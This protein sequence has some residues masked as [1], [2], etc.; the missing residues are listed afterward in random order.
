MHWDLPEKEKDRERGEK[1]VAVG[2]GDSRR[3][4]GWGSVVEKRALFLAEGVEG[5]NLGK[6]S[7][8][9]RRK[10]AEET[11]RKVRGKKV[12]L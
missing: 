7:L 5:R 3:F 10:E 8:G 2:K 11:T 6:G 9:K 12:S 1:K 4:V